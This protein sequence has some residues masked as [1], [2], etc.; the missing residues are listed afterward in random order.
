MARRALDRVMIPLDLTTYEFEG[1]DGAIHT[2]SGCSLVGMFE[3]ADRVAQVRQILGE[4][5]PDMPASAIYQSD[6][7]FRWTVDRCLILNGIKAEWCNWQI[8]QQL[9]FDPGILLEL[10]QPKQSAK[11]QEG[12][13]ASLAE[14]IA[15]I[16]HTTELAKTEPF[17][18][19][20]DIAHAYGELGKTPEQKQKDD[21]EDWADRK[22]EEAE[23]RRAVA[24]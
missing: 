14:L 2:F 20:L 1:V 5:S 15:G 9:L 13:S 6:K 23:K 24:G 19:V 21:F 8:C 10:N 18:A 17:Q 12:A 16:A 3:F 4:A 11:S 7:R 22:R